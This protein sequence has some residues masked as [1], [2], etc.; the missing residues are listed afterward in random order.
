MAP[1]GKRFAFVSG[2]GTT[3]LP[4]AL[5]VAR[6]DGS[7]AGS[8]TAVTAGLFA[9]QVVFF[10][11]VNFVTNDKLVFMA[12]SATTTCDLYGVDLSGPQPVVTNLTQSTTGAKV[13]PFTTGGNTGNVAC[14]GTFASQNGHWW[15]FVRGTG[16]TVAPYRNNIVAVDTATLKLRDIT[17]NEYGNGATTH[18]YRGGINYIATPRPAFEMQLRRSARLASTMAYFVAEPSPANTSV[19]R[20]HEVFQF[21]IENATPA[22]Q[23]TSYNGSGTRNTVR[24]ISNLTLSGDGGWLGWVVANGS[25]AT[26]PRD[27]WV[28]SA[29]GGAARQLSITQTGRV[30]ADGSIW[31]TGSPVDGVAWSVG[32]GPDP[33]SLTNAQAQWSLVTGQNGPLHLTGMPQATPPRSVFVLG[34]WSTE[35]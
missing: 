4:N 29:T 5:Y 7:D 20:D 8:L 26:D 30:V 24:V 32:D 3:A 19:Y 10:G 33:I 11:D 17:G 13:P 21:D 16:T 27:L 14:R 9:T 6:T 1:D 31:F 34:A 18:I 15:Y 25:T 22:V 2:A 23:L 28:M 12:G 35:Q